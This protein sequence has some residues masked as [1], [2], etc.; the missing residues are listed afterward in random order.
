MNKYYLFIM[1][2]LFSITTFKVSAD[3]VDIYEFGS[4]DPKLMFVID[5]SGSMRGSRIATTKNA[6]LG[7]I[8]NNIDVLYGVVQMHNNNAYAVNP[9]G[10][11][12]RLVRRVTTLHESVKNA[13]NNIQT[14]GGTPLCDTYKVAVDYFKGVYPPKI[15]LEDCEVAHIVLMSD[16]YCNSG[17]CSTACTNTA[18]DM[19]NNFSKNKSGYPKVMTHTVGL[20]ID[21]ALLRNTAKNGGGFYLQASQ[22]NLQDKFQEILDQIKFK[23]ASVTTPSLS[24]STSNATTHLDW[25]FMGEFAASSKPVWRG[26]I[27]KV[28]ID[29]T[30]G[31]L[32]GKNNQDV[33]DPTS[34]KLKDTAS[35]YWDIHNNKNCN[36]V[37]KCGVG[38]VLQDQVLNKGYTS[39]RVYTN[40]NGNL[41]PFTAST[42]GLDPSVADWALGKDREW[43]I[44]DIFHS[45]PIVLNYGCSGMTCT[46]PELRILAGTNS[47]FLHM[48]DGNNGREKWAFGP[49]ELAAIHDPMYQSTLPITNGLSPEVIEFL[50][51]YGHVFT[52]ANVDTFLNLL[53]ST[54]VITA[55]RRAELSIEFA[56]ILD[57][58]NNKEKEEHP[59]GVDGKVT[60]M[61][62]SDTNGDPTDGCNG[63]DDY[64]DSSDRSYA[65]FGLRRGGQHYY[66]LDLSGNKRDN[67]KLLWANTYKGM[68]QSWSIPV[69]TKLYNSA[70]QVKLAVVF[71]GGYDENKDTENAVGTDD[72]VGMGIYAVDLITGNLL[73]QVKAGESIKGG[74]MKD[75]IPAEVTTL[76]SDG[77]GVTDRLYVGDT[78]ANIW[79]VDLET[80]YNASGLVSGVKR[81]VFKFASLGDNSSMADDRRIF[82]RID[83]VRTYV[84][85]KK[86]DILLIGTGDH[87]GATK[88]DTQNRFYML[89]DKNTITQQ[90][91]SKTAPY[92]LKESDLYDATSNII[93]LSNNQTTKQSEINKVKNSKGWYIDLEDK[94]EKFWNRAVTLAGVVFFTTYVPPDKDAKVDTCDE[95]G[96]GYSH[97][98]AISLQDATAA[99]DYW[100]GSAVKE[101]KEDR[102]RDYTSEGLPG[103]LTFQHYEENGKQQTRL[104]TQE[105][106][107]ELKKDNDGDGK[108]ESALFDEDPEMLFWYHQE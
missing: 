33:I 16:G 12:G 1:T 89:K 73:W 6:I 72:K 40:V 20:N 90:F 95:S 65:V 41:T 103:E 66:A 2:L 75:S 30:T 9:V 51:Q 59:D 106:T 55:K 7:I 23:T 10:A 36:G 93:G 49:K 50:T 58:L 57:K 15:P 81:S 48:F 94:G 70:G 14:G 34:H 31:E 11:Y 91:N 60:V 17:N 102:R 108:P 44:G 27:K 85:G 8:D 25:A 63:D 32:R 37:D 21:L 4:Y 29:P 28:K 92:P 105:G 97:L 3:D 62:C 84:H 24:A 64:L 98:Y 67:P 61:M 69:I 45:K 100:N 19:Y 87:V 43:I 22:G 79:R 88:M 104:V 42:M 78:G 5:N 52:Q 26:N 107:L 18:Y 96:Y 39:R 53:Q 35:T 74:D 80:T 54:G 99:F 38:A 76:D 68:G 86:T 47:G 46:N 101:E 83:L 56:D 13:V 82:N 77:D 71:A